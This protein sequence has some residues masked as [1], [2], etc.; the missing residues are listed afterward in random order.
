[1]KPSSTRSILPR[2]PPGPVA[3]GLVL[4]AL[5][6]LV[7]GSTEAGI[8]PP[9][10]YG[11]AKDRGFTIVPPWTRGKIFRMTCGYGC[12]KHDN[13]GTQDHFALDITMPAG[14][15]IYPVA[16]GRVLLAEDLGSGWEP[17]GNGVFIDHQNGYQSFYAHLLALEVSPGQEV[18]VDSL[19]G[20]AGQSGS[21]ATTDHLHFVLYQ[22]AQVG[23]GGPGARGPIGGSAVVPEPFSSCT[24][25]SGGDCESLVYSDKLR[26]DDYAPEAV[27]Q[28]DG[29]LELFTCGRT[30]RNLLHRRRTAGGYWYG[31]NN[32]QGICG[33]S[34]TAVRD[35]G[36][37]IYVFVRGLDGRLYYKRRDATWSAWSDWGWLEGPV[38][39]RPAVA[40]DTASG[41]LRVFSRQ[42]PDDALYVASQ[43]GTGFTGWS[44]LGGVLVNSPVAGRR[45]DGRVDAYVA[46]LDY[47]LWKEPALANGTYAAENWS[48]EGAPIEGEPHLVTEGALEWVARSTFDQVLRQ[49]TYVTAGTHPPA[50]ARNP[51]GR[52]HVFLRDR[53]TSA[54]DYFYETS[55]GG[56]GSG[57]F[58]GLVTSELEAVRAGSGARILMFTWGTSGLYA[59]EQSSQNSTTGW[60]GWANLQVPN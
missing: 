41:L 19:L 24:Q 3:T 51:N 39:G 57:S 53:A 7:P 56:W 14:E 44:R 28:P 25:E 47:N 43:S 50:A 54:A 22:G 8:T 40:L 52:L 38:L 30:S 27:V 58:G 37:R 15:P 34:P 26:R 46:G 2:H 45:A 12:G 13:V 9:G 35:T 36:G 21:G 23:G 6:A 18:D 17:Y 55:G 11:V 33:S 49:G 4:A 29:S 10:G 48:S 32:L 59:R 16:P 1:M 20:Y 60:G 31:W 5:L 42:A